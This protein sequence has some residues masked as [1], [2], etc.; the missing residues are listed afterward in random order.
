MRTKERVKRG[1]ELEAHVASPRPVASGPGVES[2]HVLPTDR[3]LF[4]PPLN[5]THVLF[6]SVLACFSSVHG[7]PSSRSQRCVACHLFITQPTHD[8]PIRVLGRRISL[9]CD[10]PAANSML[11]HALQS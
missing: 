6:L 5:I 1:E 10:T 7:T 4:V 2:L 9:S 8:V 11:G 3:F